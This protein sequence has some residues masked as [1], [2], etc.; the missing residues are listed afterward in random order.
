[1]HKLRNTSRLSV[2]ATLKD[3]FSSHC[4]FKPVIGGSGNL[5]HT[6]TSST[7]HQIR[8]QCKKEKESMEMQQQ[9]QSMMSN[10]S[11][12]VP[13]HHSISSM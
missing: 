3:S 12:I 11:S 4:N 13:H 6:K 8:K 5:S 7:A 10:S 2:G 1:M 9:Q